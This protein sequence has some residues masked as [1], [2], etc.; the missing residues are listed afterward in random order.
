[1]SEDYPKIC[2]ITG[3]PGKV[4]EFSALLGFPVD[5][6]KLDL[7]EVQALEVRE[8]AASKARQAYKALQRPVMI[9]DTGFSVAEWNGLPGALITWFLKT[10]GPEGIVKMATGLT[11][12]TVHV[13][14]A[15]GFADQNGI[16]VFS[17]TVRG[18]IPLEPRGS[19]G[20]GYDSIFIPDGSSHTYAEMNMEEKNKL[21]MRRLAVDDMKS[22]LFSNRA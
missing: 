22:K 14:T 9:D 8:I 10:V 13:I 21:S 3:N 17:G 19:K 20:F 2:L 18:V 15:I 16:Q 1:M 4:K 11:D 7:I 6:E 5:H 12:R